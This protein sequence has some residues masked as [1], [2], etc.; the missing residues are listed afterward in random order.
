MNILYEDNH[1]LIIN[2]EPGE[3]VQGDKTGDKPLLDTLKQYIKEKYEKPGEVYL[4]APHRIDRPTTGIVVFTRTSKAHTRMCK[5]FHDKQTQKTY[6]AI[7][8]KKPE[9]NED[10]LKHYLIKNEGNNKSFVSGKENKQ[11]KEAV[12]HYHLKQSSDNYH[13][14]EIQ[15]ETGRHHQIRCQLAHIGCP[16]KGDLKYGAARSNPDKGISLHARSISFIH[17]VKKEDVEIIAPPPKD[18]LWNYFTK[19]L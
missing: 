14:L 10:T 16:I 1:L 15:L 2:K 6:W 4:G 3:L 5:L 19:H 7:V 8:Q 9:K 13:L 18:A 11:A 12:L 17:P